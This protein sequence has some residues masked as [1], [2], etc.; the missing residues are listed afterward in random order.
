MHISFELLE[1]PKGSHR[2]SQVILKLALDNQQLLF[3]TYIDVEPANWDSNK[4]RALGKEI[5]SFETNL[6]ILKLETSLL[7]LY[8]N[9]LRA[10]SHPVMNDFIAVLLHEQ[11]TIKSS[12]ENPPL[13]NSELE[14]LLKAKNL[15]TGLTVL[16][17]Q[18]LLMCFTG[19]PFK[20][21]KKLEKSA[22]RFINKRRSIQYKDDSGTI[23]SI[24]LLEV[25][26]ILIHKYTTVL[27][28]GQSHIFPS[29]TFIDW[30]SKLPDLKEL[31]GFQTDLTWA[32]ALA[33]YQ[34]ILQSKR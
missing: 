7:E 25:G 20:F 26:L 10:Q 1:N 16:R 8:N 21:I 19:I 29:Q 28:P 23:Y 6:Q 33:T 9:A 5:K 13:S 24:P 32:T 14:S 18:Y 27:P 15:N 31:A 34:Q 11:Q 12:Q 3:P 30:T 2:P 4:Q 17:D 22:L